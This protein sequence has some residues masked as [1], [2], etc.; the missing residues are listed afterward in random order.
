VS[1][2]WT[3]CAGFDQH[4]KNSFHNA[5]SFAAEDMPA[6][7]VLTFVPG[8]PPKAER[9]PAGD[10]GME[11]AWLYFR[12]G[13]YL[14]TEVIGQDV[15]FV[16]HDGGRGRA[17]VVMPSGEIALGTA[18][19]VG[20]VPG[21]GGSHRALTDEEV[22]NWSSKLTAPEK[23]HW[24]DCATNHGGGEC[25]MGSDCGSEVQHG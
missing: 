13:G 25:D 10:P 1:G 9:M 8:H 11:M 15:L 20:A 6:K 17:N 23:K 4:Y 18:V 2:S 21:D 5:D 19:L 7:T 24:A 3:P 14:R 22:A 16:L 12:V